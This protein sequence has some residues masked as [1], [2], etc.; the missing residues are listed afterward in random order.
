M[1]LRMSPACICSVMEE[2]RG[3]MEILSAF[4]QKH[5][6]LSRSAKQETLEENAEESEKCG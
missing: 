2:R 6:H 5:H 1:L 4:A 3:E